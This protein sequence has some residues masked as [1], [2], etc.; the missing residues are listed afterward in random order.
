MRTASEN[1]ITCP[2][3]IGREECV[4]QFERAF[5]SV[6]AGSGRTITVAG[7]AGI[8]KS[9]LAG[10]LASR[11]RALAPGARVLRGHCFERDASV[12]F[13]ALVDLWRSF[14]L[15]A[16]PDDVKTV[17][18]SEA[19]DIVKL[20]PELSGTFPDVAPLPQVEPEQ[21]KR[22]LF[23]SLMQPMLRLAKDAP[24]LVVVEDLH[25]SDDTS[26]E[27]LLQLARR[28]R[29]LPVALLLTYRTDEGGEALAHFLAEL[30]RERLANELSLERL[31]R[32]DVS[33]MIT[34]IFDLAEA[35]SSD[36]VGLLYDLTDGNPFFIEEV[37]KSL[38]TSGDIFYADG[39]WERKP[40][41]ELHIPRSVQDAVQQRS[42]RLSP[43]ARRLL[44]YAAVAGRRF[45]LTL[46]A[47]LS[48]ATESQM[49]SL[50]KELIAAQLVT[51]ESEDRFAFRHALTQQAIYSGLL[52]R[53]RRALHLEIADAMEAM[54]SAASESQLGDLAHHYFEAGVWDRA[55]EYSGRVGQLAQK[56]FSP[57]AAVRHFTRALDAAAHTANPPPAWIF[58]ARGRAH[59]ALGE[60]E[61]AREDH[62]AALRLARETSDPSAEWQA[63][64]DLG[65]LWATRDYD[66]AGEFFRRALDRA[67]ADGDQSMLARSL[68]RLGNWLVNVGRVTEGLEEHR[69]ALEIFARTGDTQGVAETL[70]LLG[71]AN[72]M[73][74]DLASSVD[75]Y[76]QAIERLSEL[77]DEQRLMSALSSRA[78]W[79]SPGM[80]ETAPA[81]GRTVEDARHD[82]EA[83]LAL[84]RRSGSS[85]GAAY[86]HWTFAAALGTFGCLG[87]GLV[88]AEEGLRIATEIHHE[89]WM[90][91]GYFTLGQL[92]W[93]MFDTNEAISHLE[94]GLPLARSLKSAWWIGNVSSYL[95]LAHLANGNPQRARVVL[96][97]TPF[98]DDMLQTVPERRV[99]W[100]RAELLLAEGAAEESLHLTDRLLATTVGLS[101]SHPPSP[102]LVTK[103]RAL[104]VARR[105]RRGMRGPDAGGVLRPSPG[106]P[107]VALASAMRAFPRLRWRGSP[108][109]C[110]SQ[111]GG[112][113]SAAPAPSGGRW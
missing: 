60:F 78:T 71:M 18:S 110:R 111:A 73:Y 39:S 34:A 93:L 107:A 104:S 113:A 56:L 112:S 51:E 108:H 6:A 38:T 58:A 5:S 24:L 83:A 30:D 50:V 62:E 29:D 49:L 16:E 70:D 43:G 61:R 2:I 41:S 100:A 23:Q 64:I 75:H 20:L 35:P 109:R 26:L 19:A 72:G 82:G 77:G 13:A 89:Q 52:K 88:L 65:F 14:A 9:R 87:E 69:L 25:W 36:S 47:R 105:L 17:F 1:S 55:F 80:A 45:D 57:A 4:A 12:P 32:A 81:A 37:L 102:L 101:T 92:L 31:S 46:L 86:A 53:E 48:G 91:G 98:T 66:R 96:D 84:A 7:E 22:R 76:G 67:R 94:A 97:A 79:G 59:E 99:A 103:A 3:L 95:A 8:G 33:R 68:N 40:T 27:L 28:A 74:G 21:E 44:V 90:A 63:L 42:N 106:R 15:K 10:E 85:V 54:S 11:A